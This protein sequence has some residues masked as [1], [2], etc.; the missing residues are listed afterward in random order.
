MNLTERNIFI[1]ILT[2]ACLV[3]FLLV[4]YLHLEGWI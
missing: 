3:A 1:L 4:W 2:I